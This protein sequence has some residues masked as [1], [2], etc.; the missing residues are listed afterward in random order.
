MAV[1]HFREGLHSDPEHKGLKKLF[2]QVK[3]ILKFINNAEDEMARGVYDEAAGDWQSALDVDPAHMA[4]NKDLFF[5]LCECQLHL[6]Q[7]AKAQ[8][9]CEQVILVDDSHADAHVKLSE[10]HLGQEHYDDAVRAARRAT[11]LDNSN[12]S[13]QEA[14]QRAEAA[15]KQSKNKNYYKILDIPRDAG[16][17][18]VK[19]AYRK[20]ALEWHPDKHADKEESEREAVNK[21]FQDIA[22][23]YEILSNEEQRARY[24]R[25]EDVTGNAQSQQHHNP[26][27]G[28]PFGGSQFFQQGGRTFHFNF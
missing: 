28:N 22:E 11:E 7:Y 19:K 3:K 8:A 1:T 15:L 18:D 14:A 27:G 23:A 4:M 12:H 13:Y 20:Q 24:D 9:S 10:A 2:R 5:K 26:F 25:G 21:R 6:K 17:K 16:I